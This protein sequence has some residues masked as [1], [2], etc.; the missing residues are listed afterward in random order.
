MERYELLFKRSFAKDLR[1]IPNP[2]VATGLSALRHQQI[3]ELDIGV[4]R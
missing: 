1:R 2:D 3:N 4:S